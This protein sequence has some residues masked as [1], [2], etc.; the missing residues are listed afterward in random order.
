MKPEDK[1]IYQTLNRLIRDGVSDDNCDLLNSIFPFLS[2]ENVDPEHFLGLNRKLVEAV[3][4]YCIERKFKDGDPVSVYS[5]CAALQ[6]TLEA[7]AKA[8]NIKLKYRG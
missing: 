3:K 1:A 7:T 6:L 5:V 8:F 2:D 4:D